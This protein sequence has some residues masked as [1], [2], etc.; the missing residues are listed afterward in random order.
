MGGHESFCTNLRD[1]SLIDSGKKDTWGGFVRLFCD[2]RSSAPCSIY[3]KCG[4]L[5]I[6]R[7]PPYIINHD[8]MCL[9]VH[10]I[11]YVSQ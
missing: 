8:S 7:G 1:Q 4:S 3:Y 10:I 5:T 2:G 6:H 9:L 11:I